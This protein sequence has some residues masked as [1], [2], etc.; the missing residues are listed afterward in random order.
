MDG[1]LTIDEAKKARVA[2]MNAGF[3][4]QGKHFREE[5]ADE[6]LDVESVEHVMRSGR[7][8]TAPEFDV[9]FRNWKYRVEGTEPAGK[10]LAIVFSFRR[11]GTA[12]LITVFS[13]AR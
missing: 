9:K 3:V 4:V 2:C 1:C 5:L 6:S 11:V 12:F 10:W 8:I 13:I 7:I